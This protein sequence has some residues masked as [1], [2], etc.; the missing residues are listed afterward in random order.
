MRAAAARVERDERHFDAITPRSDSL[1]QH[2]E[3]TVDGIGKNAE[4]E[5]ALPGPRLACHFG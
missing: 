2:A 3:A 4:F 1:D 5:A